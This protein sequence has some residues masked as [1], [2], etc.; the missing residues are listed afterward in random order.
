[1][2]GQ[3]AF[4]ACS[5]TWCIGMWLPIYLIH[6][7]GA[8]GWFAFAIPN[9]V[10]AAAVG[11]VHATPEKARRFR[12][13]GAAPMR[14]FSVVTIL[15]HVGFLGWMTWEQAPHWLAEPWPLAVP[16]LALGA[17]WALSGLKSHAWRTLALALVPIGPILMLLAM[18]TTMGQAMAPPPVEGVA[19]TPWA[20]A[21]YSFGL[22]FGFLLCPHL[23]LSILRVREETPGRAGS[24]AFV[25]GF[26]GF[27]LMNIALTAFYAGGFLSGWFSHYLLVYFFLQGTF[28][29]GAH[30]RELREKGWP[31]GLGPRNAGPAPIGFLVLA[32]AC[33]ALA[34]APELAITL[35]DQPTSRTLYESFLLAYALP[36]PAAAWFLL[37]KRRR[38]RLG[39]WFWASVVLAAPA[40][41]AGAVF[42]AF[43]AVP[44]GVAIP[45][46]AGALAPAGPRLS[47]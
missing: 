5:W 39:A 12:E 31:A 17:G 29:I 4:L 37:A 28:T 30:L 23:D 14:W 1:V 40:I 19:E 3:A 43:W 35:L 24:N 21:F 38:E 47:R 32:I 36:L 18:R 33:A 10:G 41:V 6:D 26:G 22:A 45:L 13:R 46:L 2:L 9:V 8:A 20:L 15:F 16:L 42:G 11:F 34:L 44:I 7:F 27:F 25:L